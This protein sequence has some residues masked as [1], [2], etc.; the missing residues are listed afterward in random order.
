MRQ[1]VAI[2]AAVN[3]MDVC[4]DANAA[5]PWTDWVAWGSVSTST[6][7]RHSESC[8][9]VTAESGRSKKRYCST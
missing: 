3:T 5:M 1:S 4:S 6:R 7:L 2:R 9:P 8:R